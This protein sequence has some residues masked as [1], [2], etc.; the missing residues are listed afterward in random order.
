MK[1]I[2]DVK[3]PVKIQEAGRTIDELEILFRDLTKK[4]IKEMNG[5]LDV[6]KNIYKKVVKIEQKEKALKKK[7]E[8]Y[9]KAKEYKKTI[10]LIEELEQL[11]EET[12]QLQEETEAIGGDGVDEELAKKRFDLLVGGEDKERLR[13]YAKVRGY[14]V[15]LDLLDKAKA[16][17]EKKQHGRL[18]SA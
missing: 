12:E 4:E 14:I 13:E 18:P 10:S 6:Y 5:S 9:E 16:D 11:Q 8:L 15:V 2:L 17:L 3:I 1:L 7:I